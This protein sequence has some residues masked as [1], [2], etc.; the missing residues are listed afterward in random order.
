[1]GVDHI[2]SL[3][4]HQSHQ[5]TIGPQVCQWTNAVA[6]RNIVYGDPRGPQAVH[7]SNIVLGMIPHLWAGYLNSQARSPHVTAEIQDMASYPGGS[8]LDDME[9]A[10][11]SAARRS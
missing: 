3:V 6:H 11:D 10:Q 4:P 7:K 5:K 8:R 9:N 1:V 2:I